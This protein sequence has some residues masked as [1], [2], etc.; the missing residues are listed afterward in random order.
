MS[1]NTVNLKVT[2]FSQEQIDRQRAILRSADNS[3]A[4][5]QAKL[6]ATQELLAWAEQLDAFANLNPGTRPADYCKA[7]A[8]DI[9]EYVSI[10][11]D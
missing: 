5:W 10:F 3:A 1:N 2:M 4:G 11:N 7:A 9:R 8:T 6:T